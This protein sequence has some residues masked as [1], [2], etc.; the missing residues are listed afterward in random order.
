MEQEARSLV[1]ED[2]TLDDLIIGGLKLIQPRKGYRFSI[3][4][5]LLAHFATLEKVKQ[6]VDLGCGNGVISLLLAARSSDLKITGIEIQEQMA[7]RAK[8]SVEYNRLLQQVQIIKGDF[9][10]INKHLL[11]ESVQLVL[12]NPPFY[13]KGQGRISQNPEEAFARHEIAM[14]LDDLVSAAYYL[15]SPGGSFCL[16][17]RCERLP[18]IINSC[19]AH[20]L[21]PVRLR[22]VHSFQE[23]EAQLILIEAQKRERGPFRMLPPLI[24]YERAGVYSEEVMNLYHGEEG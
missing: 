10:Q 13:V 8:R 19:V 4:A 17:H 20:R 18:E 24:I 12:S 3:D 14:T 16:I 15:L 1:G 22:A 23:Q 9:C 6:A 11:P 5:V 7:E 2:E 21:L